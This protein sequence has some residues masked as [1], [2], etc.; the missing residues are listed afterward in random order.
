MLMTTKVVKDP[1]F[2]DDNTFDWASARSTILSIKRRF[3]TEDDEYGDFN[4]RYVGLRG[5]IRLEVNV[6]SDRKL[7]S[8]HTGSIRFY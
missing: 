6:A 4:I 3:P 2:T 1:R 7:T 8:P 5:R